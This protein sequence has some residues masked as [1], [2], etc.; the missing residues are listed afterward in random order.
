MVMRPDCWATRPGSNPAEGKLRDGECVNAIT[1]NAFT[2]SHICAEM[3]NVGPEP[4][5]FAHVVQKVTQLTKWAGEKRP[6]FYRPKRERRPAPVDPKNIQ[7]R[8]SGIYKIENIAQNSKIGN[9]LFSIPSRCFLFSFST[10]HEFRISPDLPG[11]AAVLFWVC[12][13][14]GRF[15]LSIL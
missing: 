7:N 13:N 3:P 5:T 1:R 14:G 12:P 6:P 11:R 2:N 10:S 8:I 15:R 9:L 4:A